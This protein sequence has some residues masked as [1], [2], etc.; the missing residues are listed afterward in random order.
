MIVDTQRQIEMGL[1]KT[2]GTLFVVIFLFLTVLRPLFTNPAFA[3]VGFD[4]LFEWPQL[5][6]YLPLLAVVLVIFLLAVFSFVRGE[7]IPTRQGETT[8]GTRTDVA[9]DNAEE[10][11]EEQLERFEDHPAL[12]SRFLSGQGGARNRGFDIEEE[13]PD[14]TLGEHLEHLQTELADDEE[15]REDLETLEKVVEET[16]DEQVIPP[17]CPQEYCDA[18]WAERTILGVNTGRY[19]LLDNGEQVQCLECEAIYSLDSPD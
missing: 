7:G 6:F 3:S 10:I 1:K 8:V 15:T 16:E 11:D 2:A 12:S 18:A 14:A 19:E 5:L 13:P 9:A 17:R 4:Q